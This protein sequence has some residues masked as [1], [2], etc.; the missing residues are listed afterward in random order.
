[1]NTRFVTICGLIFVAVLSR[2][3]PHPPNFTP[4][5]AIALF[6]GAYFQDKKMAF[7]VPFVAM[8]VSDLFIGLHSTIFFVYGGFALVVLIGFL[9]KD[10]VSF[11]G[12]LG[13]GLAGAVVFFLITN[14][15]AWLAMYPHT[16]KGF[17]T[18]Y[19]A[20][21]PFFRYTLL[22]N[23]IY[24]PMLFGAFELATRKIPAL[25]T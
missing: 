22:G 23:L 10:R 3:I 25:N 21:I 2:L 6:G 5:M 8:F 12:V 24:I 11:S 18:A 1:M 4:V 17:T 15:G 19:V 16:L 20:A 13:T 7:F 14:F 9:L